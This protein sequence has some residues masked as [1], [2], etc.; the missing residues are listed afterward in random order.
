MSERAPT[1][2]IV[3]VRPAG[4]RNVGAVCRA[5]KAMGLSRLCIVSPAAELSASAVHESALHGYELYEGAVRFESLSEAVSD[6]QLV[7]GFTRRHGQ[8]RNQARYA[9]DEFAELVSSYRNGTIDLLFGN[10]E[11]GLTNEELAHCSV[12]VTIPTDEGFPSLN[13]SHAVQIACYELFRRARDHATGGPSK[14]RYR[15][16]ITVAEATDL[17]ERV[18][19]ELE[20]LG[21]FKLGDRELQSRRLRDLF[22]RAAL[23]QGERAWLQRMF[24]KIRYLGRGYPDPSQ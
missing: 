3:L 20:P 13:L 9:P 18:A 11:T 7:A 12:A 21:L 14:G 17:A 16:T 24:K 15:Q 1:I 5:M 2:R 8:R 23:T 6:S 4:A 10:E 19:G 22:V